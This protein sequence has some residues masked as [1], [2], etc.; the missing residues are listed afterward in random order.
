[1]SSSN[2]ASAKDTVQRSFAGKAQDAPTNAAELEKK[3]DGET[4]GAAGEEGPSEEERAK[5]LREK[6]HASRGGGIKNSGR[7]FMEPIGKGSGAEGF[8]VF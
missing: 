4:E 8:G 3:A 1:M 7:S 5:R 6:V 2:P